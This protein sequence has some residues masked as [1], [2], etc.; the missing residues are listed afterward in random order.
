MMK[1]LKL[2]IK[3]MLLMKYLEIVWRLF[4]AWFENKKFKCL[5]KDIY[6]KQVYEW[7]IWW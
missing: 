1:I 2:K 7:N 5:N 4:A 6:Y 3:F